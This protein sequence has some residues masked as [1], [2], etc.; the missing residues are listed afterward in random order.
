[1]QTSRLFYNLILGLTVLVLS[2]CSVLFP[3][4]PDQLAG[5]WAENWQA[6]DVTYSDTYRISK[7]AEGNWVINAPERK[8]YDCSKVAFDGKQ[9]NFT[10]TI[11]DLKY[12]Q[13]DS[14]VRYALTLQGRGK[15]LKGKANTKAGQTFN[16]VWNK[17]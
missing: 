2:S 1:M 17:K 14:W 13:E 8:D 4:K 9:L 15:I 3:P 10:V 5:L 16:V 6:P 12:G 11:K 7:T